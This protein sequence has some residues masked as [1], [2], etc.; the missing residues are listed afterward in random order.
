M[1]KK[2]EMIPEGA[3]YRI[4]ALRDFGNVK[5]GEMGGFIE[6]EYNLSHEGNCWIYGDACVSGDAR[7]YG[8][9]MVFGN[10]KVY[11]DAEVFDYACVSG[12]ARVLSDAKVCSN[13]HVSGEERVEYPT[14]VATPFCVTYPENKNS[15]TLLCNFNN[16]AIEQIELKIRPGTTLPDVLDGL[17]V[18]LKECGYQIDGELVIEKSHKKLKLF[19][20]MPIKDSN[21]QERITCTLCL[22]CWYRPQVL[23]R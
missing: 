4:R 20:E 6:K 18:F 3:F 19:Q 10:A 5:V 22:N 7:I 17:G 12:D 11:D 9:A 1:N 21:Q 14:I 2:Y 15:L 8:N 16:S 23:S 13:F